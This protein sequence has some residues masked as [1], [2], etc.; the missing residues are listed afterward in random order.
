MLFQELFWVTLILN[1]LMLEKI[2]KST[3]EKFAYPFIRLLAYF[4]IKPNSV[5]YIGLIIVIVGSFYFY[6]IENLLGIVL[7]FLG[8]A[9]DGLDGPYA[10]YINSS[11]EKGAILDSFIDRIGELIIWSV[12][13]VSY[14]DTDLELF[15]IFSI[16]VSSNL[17]P[18]IRAMSENYNITNKKGITARPER[19]IFAVLFMYFELP[20][21][22]MFIFAILTWLTVFQR[23]IF[24][25]RS[26]K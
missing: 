18:Y 25:Y 19:I 3:S 8:S 24:L 14:T 23:F 9:I 13:G 4:K 1:L 12:I 2:F 22:Y 11:S 10:R 16:L 21:V 7:I 5:S 20:F 6:K 15:I 17:I 26:L